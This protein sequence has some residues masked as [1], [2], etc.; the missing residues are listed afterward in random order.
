M[1]WA[2]FMCFSPYLDSG[3]GGG[4]GSNG[5]HTQPACAIVTMG[6]SK[7]EVLETSFFHIVIT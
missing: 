1:F 2:V 7:I 5:T 4:G 6:T 3:R